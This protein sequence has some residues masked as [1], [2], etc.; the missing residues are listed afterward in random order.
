MS[1]G[2]FRM[3][4]LKLR[5]QHST[6]SSFFP[7]SV[8]LCLVVQPLMKVLQTQTHISV[9]A[10]CLLPF[11]NPKQQ[12]RISTFFFTNVCGGH[13]KNRFVCQTTRTFVHSS[14]DQVEHAS[15]LVSY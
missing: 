13:F 14:Q 10:V 5:Y 12:E 1:G 7:P 9:V 11:D 4:I 2:L 3:N 6:G 15:K 8:C